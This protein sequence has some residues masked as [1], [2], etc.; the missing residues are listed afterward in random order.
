MKEFVEESVNRCFNTKQSSLLLADSLCH[1]NHA[2]LGYYLNK[3]RP[4]LFQEIDSVLTFTKSLYYK[5]HFDI[6]SFMA[7]ATLQQELFDP[8]N[9]KDGNA[10]N[11]WISNRTS[12]VQMRNIFLVPLYPWLEEDEVEEN[13]GGD[14]HGGHGDDKEHEEDQ[15]QPQK[16]ENIV[17]RY[18]RSIMYDEYRWKHFQSLYAHRETIPLVFLKK[19]KGGKAIPPPCLQ[20]DD[21]R[22]IIQNKEEYALFPDRI[23]SHYFS[24]SLTWE[25]ETLFW[26]NFEAESLDKFSKR[27]RILSE[28]VHQC[29][30]LIQ[31]DSQKEWSRYASGDIS[32]GKLRPLERLLSEEYEWAI[33]KT[34][35]SLPPRDA[36]VVRWL[37]ESMR[38]WIYTTTRN[39][40]SHVEE[41]ERVLPDYHTEPN[42][43]DWGDGAMTCV[44][45]IHRLFEIAHIQSECYDAMKS[46]CALYKLK[47]TLYKEQV[48][49]IFKSLKT[50]LS[51]KVSTLIEVAKHVGRACMSASD[52]L[53]TKERISAECLNGAISDD[54]PFAT[55]IN[56]MIKSFEEDK[57]NIAA[58]MNIMADQCKELWA[59]LVDHA[60]QTNVHPVVK[61]ALKRPTKPKA[62]RPPKVPLA[63][64]ELDKRRKE[65]MLEIA[66]EVCI[67]H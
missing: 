9:Y 62:P 57:V 55:L 66:R 41:R 25:M 34:E 18:A 21:I 17:D 52:A 38:V 59:S 32:D 6:V 29:V 28:S 7:N 44:F 63:R 48:D 54:L 12:I 20:A 1:Q 40:E 27:F 23:R 19:T 56:S 13:V 53:C 61:K 4:C 49:T 15:T 16:D 24:D 8:S 47:D 51:N 37:V 42:K 2:L 64:E 50:L 36:V 45:W 22:H 10:H 67:T 3:E 39:L 46:F 60:Y 30:V 35:K 33:P 26:N 43:Y 31:S 11:R 58:K 5:H 65:Q 14:D